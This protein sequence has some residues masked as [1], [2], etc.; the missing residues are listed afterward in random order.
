MTTRIVV[1]A[2]GQGTNA[3]AVIDATRAGRIDASVVAVVTNRPQAPVL[4][5]AIAAGIPAH[6]VER[7]PGEARH[8]YDTRL[9]DVVTA[10]VP[11]VVVLAGWM[12]ILTAVFLDGVGVPVVNLHPALPGEL[13]GVEAIERAFAERDTGRTGSGVMVHLVPDEAVDAG[14]VLGVRRVPLLADD[15]LE[16]FAARMHTAEH[17]LLVEVLADLVATLP[18]ATVSPQAPPPHAPRPVATHQED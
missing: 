4:G 11:D 15:T 16:I 13:P 6:L 18:A 1:L 5:R 9:R 17:E 3:Q 10:A 12:R 7:L 14:P 8:D 2:S